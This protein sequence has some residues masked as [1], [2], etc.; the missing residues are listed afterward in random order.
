[1]QSK[2]LTLMRSGLADGNCRLKLICFLI[3]GTLTN[4]PKFSLRSPTNCNVWV[5][6][7]NETELTIRIGHLSVLLYKLTLIVN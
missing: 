1:M 5:F 2:V 3:A 7:N 4:P 6:I